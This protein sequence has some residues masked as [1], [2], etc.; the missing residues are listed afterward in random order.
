MPSDAL[1]ALVESAA[2]I[3]ERDPLTE[4]VRPVLVYGGDEAQTRSRVDVVPWRAIGN[5]DWEGT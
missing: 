1:A 2:M 5:F 4:S 3:E